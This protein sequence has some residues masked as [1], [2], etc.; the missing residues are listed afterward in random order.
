MIPVHALRLNSN[1]L[2][3][4]K[5]KSIAVV[6]TTVVTG[7]S[8][9]PDSN[10]IRLKGN[11]TPTISGNSNWTAVNLSLGGTYIR[12]FAVIGTNLFAGTDNGIY[13]TSSLDLG[14]ASWKGWTEKNSRLSDKNVLS[15]VVSADST[16]LFAGTSSGVF[17]SSDNGASWTAVNTGL[18]N[19]YINALAVSGTYLFAATLG[20][21]FLS[22]NFGA[23]W[24]PVNTGLT[25]RNVYII[26][27]KGSNIF[28]GT[29][30]GV[31]RSVDNGS[32]WSAASTGLTNTDV[33]C[34]AVNGSNLFLGTFSSGAFYSAN[35]S[36]SW[37]AANAGLT[38]PYVAA[39]GVAGTTLFT[40]T[41]TGI[42]LAPN[43]N[44]SS[45]ASGIAF[46]NVSTGLPAAPHIH[47][48]AVSG[49]NLVAG[50]YGGGVWKRSLSE[51]TSPP[52]APMSVSPVE[53]STGISV[54]PTLSWN[55][56]DQGK[57]YQIQVSTDP[58]FSTVVM[59]ST[60]ITSTTFTTVNLAN[61]TTY[62]WRVNASNP[63]GNSAWSTVVRFTTIPLPE[64][65][66]NKLS[67]T[68]GQVVRNIGRR[69]TI[70]ITNGTL[71]YLQVDSIYSVQPYFSYN[72]KPMTL[73]YGDTAKLVVTFNPSSFGTFYDT[74]IIRS[75]SPGGPKRIVL[76]GASP[77]PVLS[78][79][80]ALYHKDSVAVG[81]STAQSFLIR[82]ASINELP[83]EQAGT[84]TNNFRMIGAPSG[85]VKANDSTVLTIQFKPTAF[86]EFSDTMSITSF[87]MVTKYPLAGSSPFPAMRM[88]RSSMN[89]GNVKEDSS[90]IISFALA[91][92]SINRLRID[93]VTTASR[94]FTVTK[95]AS[96]VFVSQNDSVAVAVTFTPDS[97]ETYTDT[98]RIYNNQETAIASVA[99]IGNGRLTSTPIDGEVVP[100]VYELSQNFPN[101]FNPSTT[102]SYTLPAAS[103]VRIVIYSILGQHV[104]ELVNANQT[105]GRYRVTW[106]AGVASGM[107]F[108]RIEAVSLSAPNRRFVDVKKL[109]LIR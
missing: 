76:T 25:N 46:T 108:Y 52:A 54:T 6:D 20:G 18:T 95:F 13:C 9:Q 90:R 40:G 88:S 42:F 50:T 41:N 23:S 28:I 86:G 56:S 43:T 101:P 58:N 29:D 80:P 8:D 60:G 7:N 37:N 47:T 22:Y 35:N 62:Y 27:A 92:M 11:G 67:V 109:L 53:G 94:Q 32:S 2:S 63:F 69:D 57:S 31:F 61:N 5:V 36:T 1:D 85:I 77:F 33:N 100:T 65:K 102:V 10:I 34:L 103:R 55:A 48:L 16:K 79:T 106:N 104:A 4:G 68:Y 21:V 97:I 59:N 19:T 70:F 14:G 15:I 39:L 107:Y 75:N 30:D 64:I 81:D 99:L 26:A 38:D 78:V 71:S 89:F 84:R 96:P 93:S 12:T 105:T 72:A 66:I 83:Y 87:G 44:V 17:L 3:D 98:V 74:L 82:N 51:M 24:F 73:G 45:V 91:N 49:T